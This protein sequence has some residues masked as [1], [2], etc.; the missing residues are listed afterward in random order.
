MVAACK[1][2]N[3]A[4]WKYILVTNNMLLTLLNSVYFIYKKQNCQRIESYQNRTFIYQNIMAHR[5]EYYMSKNKI[6]RRI[7][8][9]KKMEQNVD[10]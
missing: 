8:H 2:I 4:Y 1:F 6:A 9:S 7:L 5:V 3:L 10:H